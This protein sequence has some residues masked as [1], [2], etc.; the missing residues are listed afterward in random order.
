MWLYSLVLYAHSY[1]RWAVVVTALSVVI[2]VACEEK[3]AP[4]TPRDESS[5]RML[6]SLAD[7]QLLFGV[8]LWALLSP[9]SAAFFADPRHAMH[10]HVLRFFG[11]EHV[12][13][14]ALAVVV[15]HAGRAGSK[16]ATGARAR[17]RRVLWSVTAFGLLV[18]TSIPWPGLRHGRP[19]F[20]TEL[21]SAPA[22]AE[23][24]PACPALYEARCATC[25]G[26]RGAADGIAA[27]SLR[28]RPRD[29]TD[30]KWQSSTSNV[31]MH[32]VI[33]D[34][35]FAHGLS[36]AMPPQPDLTAA[37]LDALTACI[38]SFAPR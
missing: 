7:V 26:A 14:M 23:S 2:R 36:A 9:V 19:L 20:R 34:G 38:R 5:H 32:D 18:L 15:L 33:H 31:R 10:D 3:E 35:G 13:M 30:A 28:P 22:L 11:L 1:L 12:T 37:D 17:R 8:L 6:L 21:V 25:H 16:K 24:K 4:W 29:F 27:T